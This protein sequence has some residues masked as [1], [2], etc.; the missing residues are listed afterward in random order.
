MQLN[1]FW[2]PS[3]E[4]PEKSS[5]Q[6]VSVRLLDVNDHVPKLT[7]TQAFICAKKPKPVLIKAK[8]ADSA[9]FSEPFTFTLGSGKKSP[10]WEL[11]R[12]DGTHT[13]LLYYCSGVSIDGKTAK[14]YS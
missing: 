4:N 12:V 9:P 7:E 10:N 1:A 13:N 3:E 6:V 8:D 2:F 14:L 5:E 11:H